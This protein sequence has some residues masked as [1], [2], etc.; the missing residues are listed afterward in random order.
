MSMS[1]VFSWKRGSRLGSILDAE[2]CFEELVHIKETCGGDYSAEDIVEHARNES[3][4]L[5]AGFTWD[6]T[7]AAREH[8]LS[9]ARKI[10]R[11][12]EVQ[13]L[14]LPKQP[15]TRAF[16]VKRVEVSPHST[17]KFF[18]TVED[19]MNDPEAKARWITEALNDLQRLRTRYR[20]V[21]ELA[22]IWRSIDQVLQAQEI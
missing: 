18:S 7:A 20:S 13:Y 11:S 12:I 3:S 2:R 1:V 17:K 22:V 16:E 5:H 14:D 15:K 9:Q 21:Q 6:D 4:A 10:N 8:R 19:V